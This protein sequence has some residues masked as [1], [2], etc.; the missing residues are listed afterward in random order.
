MGPAPRASTRAAIPVRLQTDNPQKNRLLLKL[1]SIMLNKGN[2]P[3]T[4]EPAIQN[5]KSWGRLMHIAPFSISIPDTILVDLSDRLARAR[6]PQRLV[7][8]DWSYGTNV[9][10]MREFVDY[11]IHHYDWRAH[12][13]Q[14]NGF[15]QYTT[16]VD[17]RRLHFVHARSEDP[18]ALPLVLTHGWP[19]SVYEFYK[20]IGPL[21]APERHGGNAGDAFHVICPS[22][23]GY[24]WSEPLTE[25]GCDIRRIA[26]RQVALLRGLGYQRYGV[27][28]GDW[29]SLA[30]A[31]MA[32]ID[33][34]RVAGVHLN[35]CPAPSTD[36]PDEAAARGVVPGP[37]A[38]TVAYATEQNGYAIL[39]G[40]K[41]DQ[42][43][44]GLNDSPLGL[45]AW[46]VHCF[47]TW[48]DC[49]GDIESRFTKDELIT[50]I[51]IYWLTG[52]MPS[53]IR[54]YRETMASGRFGP[55]DHYVNTPTGVALF[56]DIARPKREWAEKIY[57]ITRWTEFD[58]G[59]H[60]ASLEEPELLVDDIREFFRP[61]R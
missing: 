53:A 27:Q 54:L 18:H 58:R 26:E 1:A 50:N 51:M 19:G 56:K 48:S 2:H 32:L 31:Y 25:T 8:S 44:F 10:Y 17:G 15:P 16:S 59:G 29:G 7:Q 40:T 43:S 30:S 24:A 47:F 20:I 38:M 37:F 36:D 42:L 4:L 6:F 35:L 45:A 61:L 57:N 11:W 12:E 14:L 28:G 23:T 22:M 34:E 46:I 21:T 49:H 41:P 13:K 33:P 3:N 55:P 39:Q 5:I 60:F 9:S 52:S